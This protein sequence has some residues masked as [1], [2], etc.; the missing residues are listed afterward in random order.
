MK[1]IL[2][3]IAAITAGH[4]ASAQIV[5][6]ESRGIT[7]TTQPKTS[8]WY[9]KAGLN[10]MGMAGKDSDDL[11]ANVGYNTTF[12]F[13]K[14]I[15]EQGAY[16][17]MEFGLGSRGW[18]DTWEDETE[19]MTAHNVQFSPFTFGWKYEV[20][21]NLSI[22]PHFGIFA[23]YDYAGK[24]KWEEPGYSES[25]KLSDFDEWNNYDVGINLGIGIWYRQFNFDLTY[26]RGFV[27][28][29]EDWKVHTNNFMIR[30][31]IAF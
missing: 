1:K 30:L 7:V 16:W 4:G 5:T 29:A 21:E 3:F 23:S 31:G 2:I 6:S 18:K 8:Q 15:R 12:G 22:D 20:I 26:Q 11:G 10:V 13:Q 27:K 9:W 17:G 14:P 28:A 24:L 25:Y 19:K